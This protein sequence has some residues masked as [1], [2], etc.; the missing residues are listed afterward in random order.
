[1]LN[2]L[3]S[4]AFRV[5]GVVGRIDFKETLHSDALDFVSDMR[6]AFECVSVE[7][8]NNEETITLLGNT[9]KFTAKGAYLYR[10]HIA[11]RTFN[12]HHYPHSSQM[13]TT[14]LTR[15][16]SSL[17][18]KKLI[19]IVHARYAKS[20]YKQIDRNKM[21][22][23]LLE[24]CSFVVPLFLF[25]V[26]DI[27]IFVDRILRSLYK[28]AVLE[29][30]FLRRE[31]KLNLLAEAIDDLLDACTLGTQVLSIQHYEKLRNLVP[32]TVKSRMHDMKYKIKIESKGLYTSPL[33]LISRMED[34]L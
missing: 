23:K 16:T 9:C 30:S 25:E 7:D 32:T 31:E 20:V 18:E 13:Q 22:G 33:A 12:L 8:A 3:K 21:Q 27:D 10:M 26:P 19:N 28:C 17:L 34:R 15:F 24:D 11:K 1:M 2:K 4:L 29:N 5:T 14:S 6:K